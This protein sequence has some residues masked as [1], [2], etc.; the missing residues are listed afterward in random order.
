MCG[1]SVVVSFQIAKQITNL[2]EQFPHAGNSHTPAPRTHPAHQRRTCERFI[3]MLPAGVTVDGDGPVEAKHCFSKLVVSADASLI[4]VA[5]SLFH[6][7]SVM[8]PRNN[9][10]FST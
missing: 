4:Q 3:S 5:G 8:A 9:G 10:A 6:M 2:R 7:A 1:T